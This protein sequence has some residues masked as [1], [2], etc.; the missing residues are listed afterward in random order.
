[1]NIKHST[2]TELQPLYDEAIEGQTKTQW[3]ETFLNS[4]AKLLRKNPKWYRAYGMYWWG[5]KK[6]LIEHE[7][8]TARF[9]DAEWLEKIEYEDPAYL[10]LA[11]YAYHDER[12][13][14]G[15]QDDDTHVIE[16]EDGTI[17]SY[18]L[19]DEELELLVIT[20]AIV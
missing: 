15:A 9:I 3:M 12:Q 2:K 19:I 8:I 17:G 6:L 11:A 4:V 14:I 13:D 20:S 16:Y 5:V 18:I 1:M 7:L 10:L